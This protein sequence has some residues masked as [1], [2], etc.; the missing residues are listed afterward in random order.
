MYK[1]SKLPPQIQHKAFLKSESGY[2]F[3]I[4]PKAVR[5]NADTCKLSFFSA[6]DAWLCLTKFH[7]AVA[8]TAGKLHCTSNGEVLESLDFVST[9]A[10][11]Q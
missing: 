1:A 4:F 2:W 6:K 11:F 9:Y 7:R 10:A 3:Y 5:L 8:F